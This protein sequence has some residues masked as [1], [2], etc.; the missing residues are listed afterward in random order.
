MLAAC[1]STATT[2]PP[3]APRTIELDWRE[4]TAESGDRFVFRVERLVLQPHR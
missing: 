4:S 3:A 1:G 2:A